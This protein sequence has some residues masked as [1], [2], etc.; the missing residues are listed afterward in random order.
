MATKQE[1]VTKRLSRLA[2]LLKAIRSLFLVLV[3]NTLL[4][5]NNLVSFRYKSSVL[6]TLK[7]SVNVKLNNDPN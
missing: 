1:F 6:F 2:R 5:N 4:L 7:V 3:S